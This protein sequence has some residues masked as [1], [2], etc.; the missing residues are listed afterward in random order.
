MLFFHPRSNALLQRVMQ[1]AV[2]SDAPAAPAALA[3]FLTS[4]GGNPFAQALSSLC[5]PMMAGALAMLAAGGRVWAL[6][7]SSRVALSGP[8]LGQHHADALLAVLVL[9]ALRV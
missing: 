3:A 1:A 9:T 2:A 8:S 4:L 5:R 7:Q 6:Q